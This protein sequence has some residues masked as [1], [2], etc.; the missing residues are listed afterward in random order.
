MTL[1]TNI[2]RFA[3][4][5]FNIDAICSGNFQPENKSRYA[6]TIYLDAF[7][8]FRR[9]VKA[10]QTA[11][12][13]VAKLSKEWKVTLS[14]TLFIFKQKPKVYWINEC[15][16]WEKWYWRLFSLFSLFTEKCCLEKRV[17]A[18]RKAVCG[19]TSKNSTDDDIFCQP[20]KDFICFWNCLN[21]IL[22][23]MYS[24]LFA[25]ITYLNVNNN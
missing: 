2:V 6:K 8:T 3:N 14:I 24:E 22:S 12:N 10:L 23:E 17:I 9:S 5:I 1:W 11:Q 25:D 20:V 13:H 19:K 4:H 18:A 15:N 7:K 21:D 16:Q